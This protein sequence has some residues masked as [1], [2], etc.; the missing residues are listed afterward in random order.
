[1]KCFGGSSWRCEHE[2]FMTE[3]LHIEKSIQNYNFSQNRRFSELS[4]L[5]C[6]FSQKKSWYWDLNYRR[7][8]YPIWKWPLYRLCYLAILLLPVLFSLFTD[9]LIHAHFLV[10]VS[11][12]LFSLTLLYCFRRLDK[13]RKTTV[14]SAFSILVTIL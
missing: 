7:L 6:N 4:I 11:P 14:F 1:M 3:G 9:I 10:L 2:T 5:N 12:V 8:C 13:I